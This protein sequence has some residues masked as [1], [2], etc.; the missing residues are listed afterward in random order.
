MFVSHSQL[1][2]CI[3]NVPDENR[4]ILITEPSM[5]STTDEQNSDSVLFNVLKT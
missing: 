4:Y 3:V 1:E 5:N 2:Q